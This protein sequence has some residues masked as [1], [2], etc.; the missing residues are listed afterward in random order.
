VKRAM[1]QLEDFI[2]S[3]KQP[4]QAAI[5]TKGGKP[6]SASMWKIYSDWYFGRECSWNQNGLCESH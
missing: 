3:V 6:Y 5:K 2:I 4:A 1:L